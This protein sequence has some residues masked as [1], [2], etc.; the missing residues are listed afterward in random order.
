MPAGVTLS[1]ISYIGTAVA[2]VFAT[3]SLA[4]GLYYLAELVEEYTVLTKK[5]IKGLTLGVVGLHLM[6]WIVDGLPFTKILFSLACHALYS[7][8]LS[9]FPYIS[10]VSIPFLS[11]VVL[12]LVDHFMWFQ[13]FANKYYSFMSIA[14]FFGICVWLVPFTYFISLSANDNALPS[15][16]HNPQDNKQKKAGILKTLFGAI[17]NKKDSSTPTLVETPKYTGFG[18]GSLGSPTHMH[19]NQHL[20]TPTPMA[21]APLSRPSSPYAFN[22]EKNYNRS[23]Y[24]SRPSS[25]NSNHSNFGTPRQQSYQ[26]NNSSNNNSPMNT[27]TSGGSQSYASSSSVYTPSSSTVGSRF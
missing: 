6:L 24:I 5:I 16:D 23:D 20:L 13:Y 17:L 27:Y 25:S 12:V 11:S 4:C 10:L 21:G 19:Q 1:L 2:F 3:L 18:S 8:N 14:S 26:G 9:N 7:T 15:F 22:P